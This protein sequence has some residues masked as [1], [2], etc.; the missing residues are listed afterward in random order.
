MSSHQAYIAG[1]VTTAIMLMSLLSFYE[2]YLGYYKDI[3]YFC[4]LCI[5]PWLGCWLCAEITT[6]KHDHDIGLAT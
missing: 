6:V 5:G 1:Q 3:M 2:L 4:Q